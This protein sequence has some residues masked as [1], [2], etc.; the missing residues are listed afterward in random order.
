MTCLTSNNKKH[1]S[2]LKKLGRQIA[3]AQVFPARVVIARIAPA[4]VQLVNL[5]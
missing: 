1:A 3:T 4:K 5:Y 2:N